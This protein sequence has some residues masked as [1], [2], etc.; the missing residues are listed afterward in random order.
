MSGLIAVT[1]HV[2]AMQAATVKSETAWSGRDGRAEGHGTTWQASICLGTV[3][4]GVKG[5]PTVLTK[6]TWARSTA[7]VGGASGQQRGVI[8][9]LGR[10]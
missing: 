10:R 4:L 1:E 5:K 3:G 2:H 6:G 9:R 7:P 8:R